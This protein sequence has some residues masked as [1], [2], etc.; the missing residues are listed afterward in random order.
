MYLLQGAGYEN[1][2]E[3]KRMYTNNVGSIYRNSPHLILMP[4]SYKSRCSTLDYLCFMFKFG[5]AVGL[6]KPIIYDR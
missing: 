3:T 4:V 6:A 5:T 2:F 1:T